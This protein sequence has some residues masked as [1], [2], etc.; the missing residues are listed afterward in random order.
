MAHVPV[1]YRV[2]VGGLPRDIQQGDL[3]AKFSKFGPILDITVRHSEVDT[4]SFITFVERHD[5]EIAIARM[6]RSCA[7]G[8]PVKVNISKDFPPN[9]PRQRGS[10]G[11]PINS[12]H[13][14]QARSAPRWS[15]SRSR[16]GRSRSRLALRDR[17]LHLSPCA[18]LIR[19]SPLRGHGLLAR[20][21]PRRRHLSPL[22]RSPLR[23]AS[24][25]EKSHS[26][27][28]QALRV[29]CVPRRSLL[30]SSPCRPS[31]LVSSRVV[32]MR[33]VRAPSPCKLRVGEHR[34]T[35]ENIPDDMSWLELTD[36]GKEYGSSVTFCRT[37]RQGSTCCGMLEFEDSEDAKRAIT[38]LNG[39]HIQGGAA[40]MRV[41][42]GVE[43]KLPR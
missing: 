18:G 40:P 35:I 19:R 43:S 25:S 11:R 3:A 34:I 7:W 37:Y 13:K 28:S 12:A 41:W 14:A 10:D 23:H 24:S 5:A 22:C 30:C 1:R 31:P 42:E 6:D 27:P 32:A 39:R 33:K 15:L 9:G 16:H 4:Y 2:W 21:R 38:E 20:G 17:K 29:R 8:T 26:R 36:L